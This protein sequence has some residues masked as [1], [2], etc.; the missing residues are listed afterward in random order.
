M[1]LR[2]ISPQRYCDLTHSHLQEVLVENRLL[3]I[4]DNFITPSGRCCVVD[5][6]VADAGAWHIKFRETCV[7]VNRRYGISPFPTPTH[8]PSQLRSSP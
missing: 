4:E 1:R 5:I 8:Q 6:V 7:I 3:K 2:D